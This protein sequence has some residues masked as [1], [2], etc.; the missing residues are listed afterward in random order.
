MSNTIPINRVLRELEITIIELIAQLETMP[1][2]R[3][4]YQHTEEKLKFFQ[5][6]AASLLL[7]LSRM[8]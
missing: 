8:N 5:H 7:R 1:M 6:C 4:Q 3:E 2:S